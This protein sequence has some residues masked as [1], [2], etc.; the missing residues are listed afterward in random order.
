MP[1]FL[2]LPTQRL[3]VLILL[4]LVLTG[5]GRVSFAQGLIPHRAVYDVSLTKMSDAE[6]VRG[7]RGT[8]VFVINDRCEGYTMETT[9]EIDMAFASGVYNMIDQRFAS[10]EAKNGRSSTFRMEVIENGRMSR[11]QRGRIDLETDGSGKIILES[12]GIESFDLPPGTLLTT[13]HMLSILESARSGKQFLSK[14]V[15]DGSFE[16]GPYQITAVIGDQQPEPEEISKHGLHEIGRGPYWPVGMAY[17]P[18][19]SSANLPDYEVEIDL[20]PGGITQAMSQDFGD[21]S[22]GFELVYVEPLEATCE[23]EAK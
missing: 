13:S 17:F 10:W 2:K 23:G 22:L 9:M 1:L 18:F 5:V 4:A 8:M 14:P 16:N 3:F 15:I 11:S 21:F 20:V 7:A 19:A 12:D 6:G